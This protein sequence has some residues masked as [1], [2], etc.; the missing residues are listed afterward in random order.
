[1]IHICF[2]ITIVA[3][4]ACLWGPPSAGAQDADALFERLQHKYDQIEALQ[5]SFTQ[6]MT[7][8]YSD[9]AATSSGTLLLKGEQYRVET[10]Q[11]T[12]VT[13]GTV[14]W[15]YMHDE[16]QV[17][18]NDA[19]RD[20]MT[21]SPTDFFLHYEER[22]EVSDAETVPLDGEEHHRLRLIPRQSDAFF[23]EVT[24]WLRDRDTLVTQLEVLDA[25]ETRM[26]F[27]LDDITLNPTVDEGTFTFT[28]PEGAE[29]VDLR[30]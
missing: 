7:S 1:M 21:F 8:A 17:L 10:G 18:I 25:N 28:P 19:E 24:L 26:V 22:Y 16:Q 2:R 12:I 15:I 29:V 30:S 13:D 20:E 3:V 27:E 11:Q 9:D 23:R 14:T 4:L 6:T 5:A